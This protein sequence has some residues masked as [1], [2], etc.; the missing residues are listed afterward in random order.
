MFRIRDENIVMGWS[1]VLIDQSLAPG[2]GRTEVESLMTHSIS[3]LGV[4]DT[5]TCVTS[6]GFHRDVQKALEVTGTVL[7]RSVF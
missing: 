3:L 1:G 5:Q 7:C 6:V 4:T 2:L